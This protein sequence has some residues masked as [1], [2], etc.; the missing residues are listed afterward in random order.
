MNKLE[1][2]LK[3]IVQI[4]FIVITGILF[5]LSI[6][7]TVYIATWGD[8]SFIK[9]SVIINILIFLAVLIL[10]Y[11]IYTKFKNILKKVLNKKVLILASVLNLICLFGF[12]FMTQYIPVSDELHVM[13]AA[14]ELISGDFTKWTKVGDYMFMYPFQN[15]VVFFMYI[16]SLI[17]GPNNY[18]VFQCINAL[19]MFLSLVMIC[20][21][22][23]KAAFSEAVVKVIYVLMPLWFPIAMY[24]TFVYGNLIGLFLALC[25]LYFTFK[26]FEKGNIRDIVGCSLC[27]AI[28]ATIKSNYQITLIAIC[29]IYIYHSIHTKKLK[30]LLGVVISVSLYLLASFGTDKIIELKTGVKTPTGIPMEAWMCMGICNDEGYGWFNNYNG[31]VFG[32]NNYDTAAARKETVDF[33][34]D[35]LKIYA[36]KPVYAGQFFKKKLETIWAEPTFQ[37][38]DIQTT[39]QTDIKLSAFI[40]NTLYEGTKGN[41]ILLVFLNIVQSLVYAGALLYFI[42]GFKRNNFYQ[43]IFAI[44][45][46]GGFLFHLVWE[47]KGQYTI[48]YF[49]LIIPYA[50]AGFL[51][52]FAT[53]CDALHKKPNEL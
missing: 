44:I 16:I 28:S 50:I 11:F 24:E 9:D 37:C 27:I 19:C 13:N 3:N 39:R 7:N 47:S 8:I 5:F 36:K 49:Y 10:G 51:R 6:T 2:I 23:R 25:A 43:L 41:E 22:L 14:A 52:A 33:M 53:L 4:I 40:E 1:T 32:K 21:I 12:V 34:K 17:A 18:V 30:P 31:Y 26:F 42:L 20:K 38:F 46:I 35:R 45:F 15:G 48:I 29:I